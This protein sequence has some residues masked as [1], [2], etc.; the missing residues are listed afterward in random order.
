MDNAVE[1]LLEVLLAL[2]CDACL[3]VESDGQTDKTTNNNINSVKRIILILVLR[4]ALIL[5]TLTT[6][7]L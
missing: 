4:K 5:T 3:L 7:I 6:G 2:V 1:I